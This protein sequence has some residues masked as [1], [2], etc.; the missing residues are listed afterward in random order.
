V[1]DRRLHFGLGSETKASLEIRWPT[2]KRQLIPDV[3]ADQL[4]TVREP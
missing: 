4:L 1:N 2:G 3:E